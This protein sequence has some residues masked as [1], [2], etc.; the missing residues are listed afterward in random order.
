MRQAAS[1]MK[2]KKSGKT[3]WWGCV[4]EKDRQPLIVFGLNLEVCLR[5]IADRA[6]LRRFFADMDMTAVAALPDHNAGA[7]KNLFG[8]NIFEQG[9]VTLL[10]LLFKL[11]NRLEEVRTLPLWLPSQILRTYRSTRSFR[12]KRHPQG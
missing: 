8:F 10:V 12:R 3:S 5:M 9:A 1:S 6:D 7:C 4:K 2:N 11:S